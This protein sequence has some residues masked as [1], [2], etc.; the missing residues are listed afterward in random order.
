LV[1]TIL[2]GHGR[3]GA[4]DEGRRPGGFFP[5]IEFSKSERQGLKSLR[6]S[7]DFQTQSR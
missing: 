5:D 2:S 6:E 3:A 7:P 1:T 4:Q